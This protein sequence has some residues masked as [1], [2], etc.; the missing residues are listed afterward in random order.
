[1]KVL[2][3]NGSPR[4]NFNTVNFWIKHWQE[5]LQ[6]V[7]RPKSSIFMIIHLKVVL[8]VFRVSEKEVKLMDYAHTRMN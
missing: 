5:P 1:M 8:A 6:Q 2:L 4:M 3:V 7:Q